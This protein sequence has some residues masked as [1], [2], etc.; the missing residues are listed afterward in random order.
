MA[1]FKFSKN[2]FSLLIFSMM[3]GAYGNDPSQG[4][5]NIVG[6]YENSSQ[7]GDELPVPPY[8]QE[9]FLKIAEEICKAY[10]IP[11]PQNVNPTSPQEDEGTLTSE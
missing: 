2:F 10:A 7:S 6:D 3:S 9:E 11:F 5:F 1:I 4:A 8:N